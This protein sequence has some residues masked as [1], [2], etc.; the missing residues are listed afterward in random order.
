MQE[1]DIDSTFVLQ[2]IDISLQIN[3]CFEA[4]NYY[5]GVEHGVRR[6]VNNE[7]IARILTSAARSGSGVLNLNSIDMFED[8]QLVHL[9]ISGY[10]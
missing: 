9:T 3:L 5:H 6:L 10:E 8:L 2:T 1:I 7:K 4:L